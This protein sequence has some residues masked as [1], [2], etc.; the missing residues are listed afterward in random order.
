MPTWTTFSLFLLAALGLLFIPGPA[1]LFVMTRSVD[2][3]RRVGVISS[4]GIG[5][6]DLIH[7]R[8]RTRIHVNFYHK[9]TH[10]QIPVIMVDKLP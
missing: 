8:G 5:A 9:E 1:V 2:Q 10:A 4:L 3:G 6:A 7:T